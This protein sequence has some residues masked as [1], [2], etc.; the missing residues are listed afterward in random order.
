MEA[1]TD[2]AATLCSRPSRSSQ[3]AAATAIAAAPTLRAEKNHPFGAPI[4]EYTS[5]VLQGRRAVVLAV[6]AIAAVAAVTAGCGG[7][8][9]S[10]ALKLD[11]VSAAVT[12]TQNAG[13]ARV[14]FAMA[15]G[16]SK[17]VRLRGTG[18]VDG[19]SAEMSFKL[20]SLA[21]Q[22]GPNLRNA[23]VKEVVLDQ[24][25][26]YVIYMQLGFLASQLPGGKQWIE[27]DLSKLG[28]SAGVD[29]GKLMSGSQ[30]EPSDMLSMLKGE[31]A[32]IKT[33]GPATVDGVATTQYRA[34]IDVAK[35]FQS[36]GLT[37]PL[38]SSM[39]ARMKKIS[40]NVWIGTDGL[41]RRVQFAYHV[42]QAAAHLS[43]TM[44]LYDYGAN[45]SI[46]APPSG[47][48]FDA[49]QLV[50]QGLAGSH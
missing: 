40:A 18:V 23:S 43:M 24:K 28:K 35:A 10:S 45:V 5:G 44:D 50:A 37:S 29:L 22:L 7:G 27:L 31:G 34:T 6:A 20:G 12:K 15:L 32:E 30:F 3:G 38:F 4:P 41:V 47:Q 25:G 17:T 49:T 11:P 36:K 8:S 33:L 42:P 21:G 39:A 19:T 48:V 1:P 13:A 14:R 46:E 26:D 16:G 2:G 9:S